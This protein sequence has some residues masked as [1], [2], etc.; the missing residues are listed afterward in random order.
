MMCRAV[1]DPLLGCNFRLHPYLVCVSWSA[2][3]RDR[4]LMGVPRRARPFVNRYGDRPFICT[5]SYDR[6]FIGVPFLEPVDVPVGGRPCIGVRCGDQPFICVHRPSVSAKGGA[7]A[8]G[9]TRAARRGCAVRRADV[10]ELAMRNR[11]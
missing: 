11:G 4:P 8:S 5:P 9:T 3:F 2:T 10:G 1:I 7:G 6:P